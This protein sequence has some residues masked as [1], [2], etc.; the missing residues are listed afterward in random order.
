IQAATSAPTAPAGGAVVLL[1][2]VTVPSG[3]TNLSTATSVAATAM[4]PTIPTLALGRLL[5]VQSFT[6]SGTYTKSARARLIRVRG[7]GP[8]GPG[9]YAE[10][11]S[12]GYTSAAGAG[13]AGAECELWID[14]SALTSISIT[15][16]TPATPIAS[17]SQSTSGS[18]VFGAYVT[19]G[20]G[21]GGGVGVSVS[22]SSGTQSVNAAGGSVTWGGLSSKVL[23]GS[24]AKSGAYGQ[25][26]ISIFGNGVPAIGASSAYG[27]A[28][29][30]QNNGSPG[31]G[32]GYGAGGSGGGSNSTTGYIGG[33]GMPSWFVIEEY[34]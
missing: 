7:C 6:A 16:G 1:Y 25:Q 34:S 27:S 28:A 18:S 21:Q 26:G 31:T 33:S 17:S 20:G 30:P 19:L 23:S 5:S 4:Y 8:G 10:P 13:G 32:S 12:T 11:N 14:V 22:N 15:V 3:V 24:F 29:S 2:T 9:G